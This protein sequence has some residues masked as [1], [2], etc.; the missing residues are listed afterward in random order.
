MRLAQTLLDRKMR[1]CSTM[2]LTGIP[3]DL[4]L[5]K[6]Q[7]VFQRKG[8]TIVQVWKDRTKALCK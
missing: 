1:A 2:R 3:C 4:E 5:K 6:R 7:S 8:D